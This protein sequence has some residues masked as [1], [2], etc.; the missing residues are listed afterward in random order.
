MD[1]GRWTIRRIF[2]SS[3][4]NANDWRRIAASVCNWTKRLSAVG[5]KDAAN[6]RR[7]PRARPI[8]W[9]RRKHARVRKSKIFRRNL[10]RSRAGRCWLFRVTIWAEPLIS[11]KARSP[12]TASSV[13]C[14]TNF[15]CR[16]L[17]SFAKLV[18]RGCKRYKT[19]PCRSERS[20]GTRNMN[21]Q[22]TLRS[23]KQTMLFLVDQIKKS[24][25]NFLNKFFTLPAVLKISVLRHQKISRG[26]IGKRGKLKTVQSS[27]KNRLKCV[28]YFDSLWTFSTQKQEIW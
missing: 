12:W 23:G 26:S 11:W 27:T 6:A 24:L 28:Q 3:F 5:V 15:T 4:T 25:L 20:Q 13:K 7:R 1:S 16:P 2:G 17:E 14:L 22:R 9:T 21:M 10:D 19:A 8:G 18:R